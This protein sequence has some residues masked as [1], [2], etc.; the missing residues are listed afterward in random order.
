M[1]MLAK[2]NGGRLLV[3]PS[4]VT[5]IH[6]EIEGQFCWI[7]VGSSEF[8]VTL[9]LEQMRTALVEYEDEEELS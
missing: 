3:K 1:M 4:A 5:A 8:P 7:V 9:N 2:R 6:E